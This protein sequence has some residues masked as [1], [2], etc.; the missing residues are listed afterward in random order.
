MKYLKRFNEAVNELVSI[1]KTCEEI[2]LPLVDDDIRVGLWSYEG[3]DS[4]YNK[5]AIRIDI[6]DAY[7]FIFLK[8]FESEIDHLLDYLN[9]EGFKLITYNAKSREDGSYVV[10]EYWEDNMVCPSCYSDEVYSG[11][12]ETEDGDGLYMCDKC[13]YVETLGSFS[14]SRHPIH[15]REFK[16][17]VI[18]QE[19]Q[20]V[21]L[22]FGKTK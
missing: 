6:G 1:R 10:N 20:F 18:I 17:L 11:E 12:G 8:K 7:Q 9:D 21:S 16:D 13:G 5:D 4:D 22:L 19:V 15:E 2:L 3:G 14:S